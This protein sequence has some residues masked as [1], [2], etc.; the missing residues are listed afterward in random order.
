VA[1][2]ALVHPRSPHSSVGRSPLR[3]NS[4]PMSA[5]YSR[6]FVE[7]T[8]LRCRSHRHAREHRAEPVDPR[9]ERSSPSSPG[10]VVQA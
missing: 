4:P 8:Y 7:V 3:T 1:V 9:S 5:R 6:T 10:S 2:I